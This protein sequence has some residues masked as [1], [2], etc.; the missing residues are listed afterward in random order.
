M[1]QLVPLFISPSPYEIVLL[2]L[3][4]GLLIASKHFYNMVRA[5]K[6]IST[7]EEFKTRYGDQLPN[8]EKSSADNQE[9]ITVEP[10]EK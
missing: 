10:T 8:N 5:G 1:T 6:D 4:I 2:L 7:M 3:V 9:E